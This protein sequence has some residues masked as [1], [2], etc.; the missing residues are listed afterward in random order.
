MTKE[1]LNINNLQI[2]FGTFC[3]VKG[4]SL[5]IKSG[6]TVALVGE[7]GSGKSVTAMSILRLL[8]ADISG[9]IILNGNEDLLSVSQKRLEEI[10]GGKIAMIFQEPMVSL[11]PLH[12][13]GKQIMEVLAIHKQ[14]SGK[15]AKEKAIELLKTVGFSEAQKRIDAFPHQ[16]SGGQRQRVMIAMALA[17]EPDLLIADEPTT[18]LDVTIQAQ[19]ITLL[20]DIQKRTGMAI[21][22][23]S[24]DLNLVRNIASR[25]AVMKEGKIVEEGTTEDIFKSPKASYTIK[26]LN[27]TPKGEPEAFNPKSPILL[28]GKDISAEYSKNKILNEV[29]LAIHKGSCVG[30]VGESGSGKTTLGMAVLK[31]VKAKGDLSFQDL[32]V[33]DIRPLRKNLQIVF[34]DPYSSLNPRMNIEQIVGEGLKIYEKGLKKDELQAKVLDI[35]AKTGLPKDA[36]Y[37]YPHEFSGG[38]R[39]RIAIARALILRPDFIVLDEPTSALDVSVQAQI[40]DLLRN[41][42]KE[43]NLSFLLISHDMKIIKALADYVA[44]MKDGRII[45][46]G[47]NKD[48]FTAPKEEYTKSLIS[49]AF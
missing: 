18:A 32:P 11:N 16:L 5:A 30:L 34:Q 39:Q 31:L 48:I 44:V 28:S 41:L 19:I 3:A 8:K 22:F 2:N 9:N 33:K 36:L 21:L 47:M 10:R 15:R 45:E 42:K 17:G 1:L 6:E 35:L 29:S 7:S 24:H 25:I 38:Q 43:F 37:R 4:I 14:L 26:L 46:A 20:K 23:I 27:S 49:A 40:V 12:T 13:I